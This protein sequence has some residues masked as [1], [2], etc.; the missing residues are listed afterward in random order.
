MVVSHPCNCVRVPIRGTDRV[1]A[2]AD[3]HGQFRAMTVIQ[4][5]VTI[6][7]VVA[8]MYCCYSWHAA[9]ANVDACAEHQLYWHCSNC[10]VD[11]PFP[12]M[13]LGFQRLASASA[14][15]SM[16]MDLEIGH[17]KDDD[18]LCVYGRRSN[19]KAIIAQIYSPT[20][21]SS[22]LLVLRRVLLLMT[23]WC[24]SWGCK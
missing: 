6:G 9:R 18:E 12:A 10:S 11:G 23:L 14:C 2:D 15:A 3:S 17:K 13:S 20:F 7:L 19:L 16:T 8:T 24:I 4:R 1:A 21:M 22:V 5:S